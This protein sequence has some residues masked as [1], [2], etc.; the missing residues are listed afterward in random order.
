MMMGGEI[1]GTAGTDYPVLD[2]VPDTS[3]SC[4]DQSTGGYFAD[5]EARC[6]ASYKTIRTLARSP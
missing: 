6:Q 2:S 1:P 4:A 5:V 3:F